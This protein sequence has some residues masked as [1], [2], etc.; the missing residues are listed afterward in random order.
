MS[1]TDRVALVT[2]AYGPTGQAVTRKLAEAG[3]RL[4][5]VGHDDGALNEFVEQLTV[6]DGGWGASLPAER[7]LALAVDVT[8]P[9]SVQQMVAAA[10][11]HFG[12]IDYLF[13]IVGGWSGGASVAETELKTWHHM[14]DMNLTSTFLVSRAV[15]PHMAERGSGKI[16]SVAS[17]TATRSGKNRAAYAVAKAGVLKLTEAMAAEFKEQG[18]N[19]NAVMPSTI[20]TPD[21]REAMPD[22]DFDRWVTADEVADAMLWL[23]SDAASAVHGAALPVYG[24][25]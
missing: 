11:A 15:L 22:A 17:K 7:L 9:D 18:I 23:A 20:D 19:V 25:A 5:L 1:I 14:L 8:D 4:V 24:R 10:L 16:V 13:N 3:V 6:G 21:N 2:G 12:R